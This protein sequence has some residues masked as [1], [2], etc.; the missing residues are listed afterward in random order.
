[1]K[2]NNSTVNNNPNIVI[3]GGG[4][5]GMAAAKALRKTP[6]RVFV[7][8]RSNHHLFQPL[9][10]QVATSVLTPGQIGA[11]LRKQRNTT[12]IL[13]E[14]TGV[15]KYRKCVFVNSADRSEVNVSYDYLVLATGARHSYFGH[16]EFERVRAGVE[17]LGGCR[18]DP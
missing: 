5:G 13:G 2:T 15:D 10:Y 8:D 12:I 16:N 1:M 11:P 3:V 4:F 9:L 17:K 6:A 18:R 7:F 14:V